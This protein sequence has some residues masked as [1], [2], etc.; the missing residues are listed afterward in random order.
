MS[1]PEISLNPEISAQAEQ[2]ALA[3]RRNLAILE[4]VGEAT[5]LA[6]K[7][8]LLVPDAENPIQALVKSY[9]GSLPDSA[10]NTALLDQLYGKAGVQIE[11]ATVNSYRGRDGTEH[12]SRTFPVANSRVYIREV[13]SSKGD[14][15]G[16]RVTCWNFRPDERQGML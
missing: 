14:W 11:Q 12:R 15:R 16:A 8:L 10:A 9:E 3:L 13:V 5:Q 4:V 2:V 1:S 7:P 6:F